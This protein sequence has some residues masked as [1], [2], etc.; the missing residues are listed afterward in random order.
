M[1]GVAPLEAKMREYRLRWFGHV[2]C[3]LVDAVVRRSYMLTVGDGRAKLTL[4]EVVRKNLRLYSVAISGNFRK[5]FPGKSVIIIPIHFSLIPIITLSS[6]HY[7]YSLP[8][9]TP[10]SLSISLQSLPYFQSLSLFFYQ[11][12]TPTTISKNQTNH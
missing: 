7:P 10:I 8:I 2:Y 5:T 9:I 1:V 11:I 12:I 3:R 6:N 4:E